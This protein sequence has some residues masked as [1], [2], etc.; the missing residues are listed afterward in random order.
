MAKINHP[1]PRGPLFPWGEARSVRERLV[2]PSQIARPKKR[3]KGDP[4]D[5]P[6]PSAELM[7]FIG[8]ARSADEL[9]LPA[10]PHA[11]RHGADLTAFSDRPQLQSALQ[12]AEEGLTRTLETALGRLNATPERV[13]QL[14]A[15]LRREGQMLDLLRHLHVEMNEIHRRIR[16]EQKESGY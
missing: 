9:R 3:R 12:R 8:P 15:L 11:P 13:E 5:P 10:P 14:E 7:D 16:D 2:D 4:N 6:L 1:P